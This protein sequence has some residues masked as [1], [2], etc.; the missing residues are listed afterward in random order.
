MWGRNKEDPKLAE[1]RQRIQRIEKRKAGKL[2]QGEQ[3]DEPEV[4]PY[5]ATVFV[6]YLLAV[7]LGFVLT[8]LTMRTSGVD[9]KLGMGGLD[10]ILFSGGIPNVVGNDAADGII[11]PI[12]RGTVIFLVVGLWPFVSL[13][14]VR[15]IDKPNTNPYL[16]T[17]G[18]AIAVPLVW[19]AGQDYLWPL[20]QQVFDIIMH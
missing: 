6:G 9:F 20:L 17:W 19:F 14:W 4:D 3:G 18:V 13:F 2:G 5:G 15:L 7:A 1:I 12:I 11:V 10:N 16:A 8:F